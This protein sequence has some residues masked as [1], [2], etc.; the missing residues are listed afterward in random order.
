MHILYVSQYFPPEGCAPAARVHE[1]SRAWLASGHRV[2]V[3]TGFPNHPDGHVPA[4]YRSA[5]RRG[6]M[7]EIVDGIDVTR[8]WLYP[9]PNRRPLERIVNYTTFAASAV[10]RGVWLEAPDVVI[11]TSPQLLVGAVGLVLARRFRRPFVFEVRDLWPEFLIA[12]GIRLGRV[13]YAVLDRLATHLYRSADLVVPVVETYREPIARRAPGARVAVVENGVDVETFT[14]RRAVDGIRRRLGLEGRFVVAYVGTI[15]FA[16]GIDVVLRAAAAVRATMPDVLFLVVGGGAEYEGLRAR[17]RAEGL[18]NVR[19]EGQRPRQ[20]VPDYIAAADVCLVLL[21]DSP[22]FD[23]ALPTKMLECMACG[24]AVIVG[25]N[26]VART[27]VEMSGGGVWVPPGDADALTEAI[28]QFRHDRRLL[29]LGEDGRA[30]VARHFS[31]RAKAAQYLTHLEAVI[32]E[33]PRKG[34]R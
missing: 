30:Y 11:A 25:V 18:T 9:A 27:I 31:R 24:R 3:L 29:K 7:R 1:L 12:S 26:G 21:R 5:L 20:E 14:P 4:S 22:A 8:T 2:T 6:T 16:H 10:V 15:G 28:Q 13:G 33:R 17:A 23:R 32:A 19:F 34:R